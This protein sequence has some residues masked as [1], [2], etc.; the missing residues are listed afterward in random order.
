MKQY[1]NYIFDFYGTLVDIR[2]DEGSMSLWKKLA[3]LYADYGADYKP[4]VLKKTY[5]KF[6]LEEE[7]KLLREGYTNHPEINLDI[8]FLRLLKEAPK[9]HETLFRITDEREWVLFLSN[10]F[11]LLSRKKLKPYKNTVAVLKK[12][13]E[14]GAG[15]YLLSN[16]QKSFTQAEIEV[17]GLA[18]LF[19]AVYISSDEGMK[20]PE[21]AFMEKLLDEQGLNKEE[22]VMVGNDLDSDME[23]AAKCGMDGIL[24]NTF[25]YSKKDLAAKN[26]RPVPV[27]TD[28]KELVE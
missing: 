21:P 3:A 9:K 19:D 18:P 17:T 27:I 5:F 25:P 14:G 7:E 8:V 1:R 6:V 12:L 22:C 15:V 13:K 10:T 24:L 2:T 20:K 16:A 11:R 23:L 28:I 4:S 26:T